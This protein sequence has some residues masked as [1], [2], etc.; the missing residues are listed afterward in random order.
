MRKIILTFIIIGVLGTCPIQ[1]TTW[2]DSGHHIIEDGDVYGEVFLLN[3][4]TADVLGGEVLK[5]ETYNFSSADI[6]G[7]GMDVLWTNDDTMVNIHGGALNWLAAFHNSTVNLCAYDV[8]YHFTG[9]LGD[10]GWIE[11]RYYSDNSS[12]SFSF[13]HED[14]YSHVNVVPEPATFLLLGL[15]GLLLRKRK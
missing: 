4:A 8:I 15:G 2:W 13:Y 3:D 7:G 5:L 11:G 12:F 1:A 10:D 6:F 9:G 14:S